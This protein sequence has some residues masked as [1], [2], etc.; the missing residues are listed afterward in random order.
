VKAAAAVPGV[1]SVVDAM[2]VAPAPKASKSGPIAAAAAAA[3][4]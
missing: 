1:S 3:E 2:E 4:S